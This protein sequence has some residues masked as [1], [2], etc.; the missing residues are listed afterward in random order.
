MLK[1]YILRVL[2]II[3]VALILLYVF[4]YRQNFGTLFFQRGGQ[5]K[6]LFKSFR[7]TVSKSD[8]AYQVQFK[9]VVGSTMDATGN[10]YVRMDVTVRTKDKKLANTLSKD[11]DR[12]AMVLTE[13]LGKMRV[14]EIKSA[15]GKN[16]LKNN[17][18]RTMKEKFGTDDVDEIY[19]ENFVY[20]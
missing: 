7:S 2:F 12:T 5:E 8:G 14:E 6:S 15:A 4:Q 16:I 10:V 17:I 20:Q 13:A 9:D 19:F 11:S 1:K 18:K 3:V